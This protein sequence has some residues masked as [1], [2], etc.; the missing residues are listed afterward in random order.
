MSRGTKLILA[1]GSPRRKELLT[2]IGVDFEVCVSRVEE[3]A[4]TD[5]PWMLVQSLS[6]QKAEAVYSELSGRREDL[7]VIGA[8]T[9]VAW[10]ERILGKPKSPEQAKEMLFWLQGRWHE[11]YTG[12]TLLYRQKGKPVTRKCFYELTR[13]RFFPM[14]QEEIEE[15]VTTGDPLDKAGAYGI[16][17]MCARY[18]SAVEGDYNNVVGLPVGRLYQEIKKWL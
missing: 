7:L 17:G 5:I 12:V 2:Q 11:V 13:V 9:V 16:Q 3:N 15:Y 8:D 4:D 10:N 6:K 1:S 14:S 18:I